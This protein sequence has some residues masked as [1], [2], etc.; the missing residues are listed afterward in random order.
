MVA[1]AMIMD[2]VF[3]ERAAEVPL[4]QRY[5][6]VQTLLFDRPDKAFRVRIAVRRVRVPE[7]GGNSL[8]RAA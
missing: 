6:A 5:Q 4:A 8:S 2:Q 1:F 3:G 7:R